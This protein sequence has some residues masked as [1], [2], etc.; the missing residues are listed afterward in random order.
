MEWHKFN[1]FIIKS[2][3]ICSEF[4]LFVSILFDFGDQL[5]IYI[6]CLLLLLCFSASTS[7]Q[8]TKCVCVCVGRSQ[9]SQIEFDRYRK[10]SV[11]HNEECSF[12]VRLFVIHMYKYAWECDTIQSTICYDMEW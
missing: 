2:I 12:C 4:L 3:Y 9:L 11:D 7:K 1:D 6:Q 10:S 5:K 8:K